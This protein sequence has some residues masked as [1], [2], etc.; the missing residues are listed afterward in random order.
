MGG[1]YN[2][3]FDHY[4]YLVSG[5]EYPLPRTLLMMMMIVWKM[6][7]P[8]GVKMVMIKWHIVITIVLS[9]Y[10]QDITLDSYEAIILHNHH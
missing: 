9:T 10:T 8:L 7:S 6:L 3:Y 5:P 2:L 4:E 1:N